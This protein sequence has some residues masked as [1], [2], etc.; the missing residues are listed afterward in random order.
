VKCIGSVGDGTKGS[1]VAILRY[2]HFESSADINFSK[3]SGWSVEADVPD[4][5]TRFW[6]TGGHDNPLYFALAIQSGKPKLFKQ[7]GW[8]N[9]KT[10]WQ[11]LNVQ[12]KI[13]DPQPYPESGILIDTALW[14]GPVFVNPYNRDEIYVRP[15]LVC[16]SR[17]TVALTST[18]TTTLPHS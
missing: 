2:H 18:L 7:N 12:G 13:S 10:Q 16:A 14:K 3:G 15:P 6:A 17:K 9:G 11:E 1:R 4:G 5:I 8:A